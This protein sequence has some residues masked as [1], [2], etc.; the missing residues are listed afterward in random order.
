MADDASLT[1]DVGTPLSEV[2]FCVLDIETAGGSP[3]GAGI[4]EIRLP[5]VQPSFP[6]DH[7]GRIISPTY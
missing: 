4:T 2:I 1:D 3:D 6:E 5:E 7:F